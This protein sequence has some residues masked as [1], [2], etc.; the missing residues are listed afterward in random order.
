MDQP[1]HQHANE[2][3]EAPALRHPPQQKRHENHGHRP[4]TLANAR[5][6]PQATREA[7]QEGEDRK[8]AWHQS[9]QSEVFL[10]NT[11]NTQHATLVAVLLK[12]AGR[13]NASQ[14][15]VK[16]PDT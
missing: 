14:P 16:Q 9:A 12:S 11:V 6:W 3:G 1:S 7:G 4:P 13:L 8:R 15:F 10:S 2:V 5:E